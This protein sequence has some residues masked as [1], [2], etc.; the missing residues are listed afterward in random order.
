MIISTEVTETSVTITDYRMSQL[1][2]STLIWKIKLCG[3]KVLNLNL[4]WFLATISLS[5]KA[6]VGG[7]L[8]ICRCGVTTFKPAWWGRTTS[9]HRYALDCHFCSCISHKTI[10][11][12][13]YYGWGFVV[14]FFCTVRCDVGALSVS[15]AQVSV[16]MARIG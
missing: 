7:N 8:T 13:E 2:R 6:D 12:P 5:V 4:F 10:P 15:I 9:P 3:P 14:T 16:I 1:L 11:F